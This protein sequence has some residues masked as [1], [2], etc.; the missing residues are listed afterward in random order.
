[1][2]KRKDLLNKIADRVWENKKDIE[3]N[4]FTYD[5]LKNL[6]LTLHCYFEISDLENENNHS[7]IFAAL[8]ISRKYKSYDEISYAFHVDISTLDR[9]RQRYNKLAKTLLEK[10]QNLI[11]FATV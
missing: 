1:M 4:I 8:Y 3:L 10:P 11:P 5:D 6:L 7:G 2:N 9:Y